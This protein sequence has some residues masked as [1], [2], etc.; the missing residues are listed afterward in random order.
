MTISDV[1]LRSE[2][3]P[4]LLAV[5]VATAVVAIDATVIST[6][7][8]S[9]V[10]DIGG[11]N[12]FA[13]LF[14]VYLLAQSVT[15]PVYAKLADTIGRKRIVQFGLGVFLLGS[16][17]C[18]FAWDMPSLIAFRAVQGIGAG[19]ILPI[20]VTIVG[21][22]YTIEER[23][24]TQGYIASVWAIA[25]VAGPALGGVFAM[26]DFWRGIFLINIPLCALAMWLLARDY[27]ERLERTKH[28]IDYAG[29]VLLT[30]AL[31]LLL[32]GVLEGGNSWAWNSPASFGVFGAGLVVL[33]A[34]ALVERRA[35]EPVLP[36]WVLG[37]RL[38]R[39]TNLVGLSVGAALIGL[40]AFVPTYLVVGI[41]ASPLVAGLALAT[42]TIGWPIAA[43]LSG[44][45]YLRIGFRS[46][47]I[48]GA[49][50]VVLGTAALAGLGGFP[51]IWM[52]ALVSFVIGLGFGFA[53]VPT[54]VA[55]Q[56]SVGWDERGVVT[57]VSM[58]ARSIGQA[59]G[60]AVLGAVA[61]AVIASGG[62][63]ETDPDTIIQAST[64]VFVGAAVVAVLLLLAT[65]MMPR[66]RRAPDPT[67]VST[68]PE[69]VTGSTPDA[70]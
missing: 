18:A 34:F 7:V 23:A 20:T 64:A 60:A 35:A 69:P 61:N 12:Q 11:F 9:I 8:P 10:G 15:V 14:S 45:L 55:A 57:G 47:S 33:V 25:A 2:R 37:R 70:G 41:A 53:A 26:W 3:G 68:A 39:A 4:I 5:M 62:G 58:F 29:A 42:L 65:L 19:A 46:T 16:I 50:L 54:L 56:S 59:V 38:L 31:T 52:V 32:L 40:T 43:W 13:W 6:A 17:L 22:I 27:H 28:R 21:D 67:A 44:R 30:L 1:G 48:I 49:V 66:E 63:D 24:R 51:S 36:L